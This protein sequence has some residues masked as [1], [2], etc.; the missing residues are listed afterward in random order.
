MVG[1][2]I[3]HRL[4]LEEKFPSL[5]LARQSMKAGGLSGAIFN[6]SKEVA[7]DAFIEEKIGFLKMAD[8]VETVLEKI[9]S[10][11]SNEIDIQ[12]I[13]DIDVTAREEAQRLVNQLA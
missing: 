10:N 9:P 4:G 12:T 11:Y 8:I 3:Y 1:M 2:I 7:L 13:Y 6:A 5:R